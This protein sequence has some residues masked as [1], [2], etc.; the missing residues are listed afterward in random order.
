MAQFDTTE[1]KRSHFKAPKGRGMWA[2]MPE[3]SGDPADWLFS[4]DM[5][6]AEAKRWAQEQ[7]P[8]VKT[9]SVGP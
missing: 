4:P 2:F 3:N 7:R 6:F 1:Y 8:D 5:T 9:F